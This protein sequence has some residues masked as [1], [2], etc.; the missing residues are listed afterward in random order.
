MN[1]SGCLLHPPLGTP[2]AWTPV[3]VS[4]RILIPPLFS[5]P[6]PVSL[7][8]AF[9]KLDDFWAGT[10]CVE[11][12][13]RVFPMMSDVAEQQSARS[14]SK[15]ERYQMWFKWSEAWQ[16]IISK[17]NVKI[18]ILQPVC[19]KINLQDVL[20]EELKRNR[21]VLKQDSNDTFMIPNCTKRFLMR[22]GLTC[23]PI[24]VVRRERHDICAFNNRYSLL[25]FA[26]LRF[27]L[28]IFVLLELFSAGICRRKVKSD[29]TVLTAFSSF[30]Y[31]MAI[32][33]LTLCSGQQMKWM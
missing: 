5:N 25:S 20:Y 30:T 8:S 3:Q 23:L 2:S 13:S 4:L 27:P 16:L 11:I 9:A 26:L 29:I 14:Q 10:L 6:P 21:T 24:F 15:F 19:L 22:I 18:L 33:D 17:E 32:S 31:V 12:L 28:I 7:T 1:F